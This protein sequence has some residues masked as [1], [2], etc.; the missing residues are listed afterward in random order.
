[1]SLGNIFYVLEGYH[2]LI[3]SGTVFH[4]LRSNCLQEGNFKEQASFHSSI[5]GKLE[6]STT[7]RG[8]SGTENMRMSI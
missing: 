3:A 7:G 6:L 8:M 5:L 4:F 2:S 1:M